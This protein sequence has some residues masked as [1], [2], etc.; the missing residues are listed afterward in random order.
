MDYV[1]LKRRSGGPCAREKEQDM[2]FIFGLDM[3]KRHQ[4]CIDLK[5]NL[6]KLGTID[7]ARGR[8]EE[9]NSIF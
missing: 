4:C 9:T 8:V 7:K 5:D 3:L 2:D 6:L 1:E